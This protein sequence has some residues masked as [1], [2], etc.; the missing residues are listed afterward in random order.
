M[1]HISVLRDS[2]N[3]MLRVRDFRPSL[4]LSLIFFAENFPPRILTGPTEV[5]VTVNESVT[6]I[7][8]AEDPNNDSLTFTLS[9]TL[10]AGYTTTGDASSITL[11]WRVTSEEV[12]VCCCKSRFVFSLVWGA[13]EKI[14]F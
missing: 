14:R 12:A 4:M 9:G 8:T 1:P 11:T 13:S 2:T 7:V 3:S 10:P 6:I 5:N